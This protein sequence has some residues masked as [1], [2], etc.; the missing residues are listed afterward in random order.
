MCTTNN[1]YD[2]NE[3]GA[4]IN[5]NDHYSYNTFLIEKLNL[6]QNLKILI[7]I[8]ILMEH[9]SQSITQWNRFHNLLHNGTDFTIYYAS[10][11]KL[12]EK[13]L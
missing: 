10:L 7:L 6:K 5:E 2:K 9:I 3:L 4:C 12:I 8:W 11:S 13:S 1:K